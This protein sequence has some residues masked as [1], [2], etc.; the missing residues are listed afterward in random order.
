MGKFVEKLGELSRDEAGGETVQPNLRSQIGDR[1]HFAYGRRE[2]SRKDW[3]TLQGYVNVDA[4]PENPRSEGDPDVRGFRPAW[5]FHRLPTQSSNLIVET[6]PLLGAF[7]PLP[8]FTS[9]HFTI[10]RSAYWI[11]KSP[12]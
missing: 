3:R 11:R 10:A 7:L 6:G 8:H 4:F 9:A 12:R 1:G 2:R 5:I